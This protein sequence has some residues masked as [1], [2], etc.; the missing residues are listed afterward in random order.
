MHR[1]KIDV[2]NFLRIFLSSSLLFPLLFLVEDGWW[3]NEPVLLSKS[4]VMPSWESSLGETPR[5]DEL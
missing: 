4:S 2:N 3:R 1:S 5:R